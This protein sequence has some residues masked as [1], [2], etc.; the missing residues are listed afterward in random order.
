MSISGFAGLGAV[1][2][3]AAQALSMESMLEFL[4]DLFSED[5]FVAGWAFTFVFWVRLY[6]FGS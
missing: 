4:L 3:F 6:L 5:T 2:Y 1:G